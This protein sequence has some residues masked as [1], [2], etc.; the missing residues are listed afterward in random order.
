MKNSNKVVFIKD[1]EGVIFSKI[2][3]KVPKGK[4]KFRK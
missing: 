4:Y 3:V 2:K 1:G